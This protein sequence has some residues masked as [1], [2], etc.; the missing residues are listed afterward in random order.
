[1][2]AK[3]IILAVLLFIPTVIFA[4]YPGNITFTDQYS[5]TSQNGGEKDL[6]TLN[7]STFVV[8]W[9]GGYQDPPGLAAIGTISDDT[10]IQYSPEYT[11]TPSGHGGLYPIDIATLDTNKIVITYNR[12]SPMAV[13]GEINGNTITFGNEFPLNLDKDVYYMD[14]VGLNKD[15]FIVGYGMDH[16][17]T[18][19]TLTYVEYC[20][21]NG[22]SIFS[23]HDTAL[24][25]ENV[26]ELE[27]S[28]I[29][30]VSFVFAYVTSPGTA[31]AGK[32][33]NDRITLGPEADYTQI[34]SWYIDITTVND[35]S[36]VIA[37]EEYTGSSKAIAGSVNNNVITFG[38]PVS[39]VNNRIE[40][41]FATSLG[42]N[43][44]VLTYEDR[45]NF[46]DPYGTA[47][48]GKVSGLD[49]SYLASDV[50]SLYSNTTKC[51]C[52]GLD[53]DSFIV[54]YTDINDWT[55]GWAKKGTVHLPPDSAQSIIPKISACAGSISVPL[56]CN[57]LEDILEFSLS[58][59][60]D[61]SL[62]LYSS[63][64]NVNTAL[65]IDSL[66]VSS[67]SSVINMYYACKPAFTINND[68]LLELVFTSIN[69]TG[70][71]STQV[72][73]IDSLS[74]YINSDAD[75]L[76]SDFLEDTLTIRSYPDE[77]GPIGGP[78]QI[79]Q[80]DTCHL[81]YLSSVFNAEQYHWNIDPAS[82]A[83]LYANDTMVEV[84][85][86]PAYSGQ[87]VLSVFASNECGN[88]DDSYIVIAVIEP[89]YSYAGPDATICENDSYTLN[90]NASNYDPV[91]WSTSGDGIFDDP[92]I[93]NASY[94][95]GPTDISNGE[96]QLSLYAFAI[97]NCF[98]ATSDVMCLNIAPLPQQA[99]IPVGPE[100]IALQPNLSSEYYTLAVENATDYIWY[101]NPPDAGLIA[102]FDTN[103]TVYWNESFMGLSAYVNVGTMNDCGEL[104][105]DTLSVNISPVG[106]SSRDMDLEL[107]IAPNPSTGIVYISI[108]RMDQGGVMYILNSL[109]RKVEKGINISGSESNLKI[110]LSDHLTGLY[111]IQILTGDQIVLK[112]LLL[113]R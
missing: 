78:S 87:A 63:C 102:G 56:I 98:Y 61:T 14:V 105:S 24:V 77:P 51:P 106:I 30:S 94:I 4:Q 42:E 2:K 60:I 26:R 15:H 101:L 66:L 84:C 81:Y 74:Y 50:F 71:D 3:Q 90:G 13:I 91:C 23:I 10:I 28:S 6:C 43:E 54:I 83:S 108:K 36:F 55:Q 9:R 86:D 41:L 99:Q 31:R 34:Y 25:Y 93:L 100:Y 45:I 22:T 62:L 49:I 64:Q 112:K 5:Y 38:T 12:T 97:A 8:A 46:H 79:C 96:V 104:L 75:T 76:I 109:G 85:F 44:F 53:D 48:Y 103:A 37:Y 1:M 107:H 11:F 73:W 89:P 113:V 57:N 92:F 33:V 39:F 68:T 35:S 17:F 40:T 16:Y 65:N 59:S 95:L 52:T 7:D 69:I 88:S 20:G 58:V 80:G 18:D 72:S 32:I 82:A 110:D 29:D 21:V 70:I 111:Y 19:D 47:T 27:V 67:D